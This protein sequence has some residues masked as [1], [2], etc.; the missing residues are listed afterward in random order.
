MST[1]V[2]SGGPAFAAGAVTVTTKSP[3][4]AAAFLAG[5]DLADNLRIPEAQAQYRRH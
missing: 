5:R 2:L 4:A 3:E 1:L